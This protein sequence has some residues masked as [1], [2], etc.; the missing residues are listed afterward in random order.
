MSNYL[1]YKGY[2][3]TVEYSSEDQLLFGKIQFVDSLL[4][5]DGQTVEE[6]QSAF[7]ETVDSYLVFCAE[8]GKTPEKSF[9]GS[10]NIRVGTLLHKKA[11]KKAF[12]LGLTLNEFTVKALESA[13][14]DVDEKIVKHIHTHEIT[15]SS[16][17]QI[18]NLTANTNKPLAWENISET[19]H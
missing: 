9:N 8:A 15:S 10:F 7:Q 6:I 4:A 5:Y 14:K 3:G 1:E 13:V 2:F 12:S 16:L 17:R 18:E 11:A 19:T